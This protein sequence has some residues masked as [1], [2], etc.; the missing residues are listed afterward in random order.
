MKDL[1]VH[2]ERIVRPIPASGG[3][4]LRM[5]RELLAHLTAAFEEE[6]ARGL[7]D[8]A[9]AA[10]AKRRL[11]D[12]DELRRQLEQPV[13][14]IER[15]EGTYPKGLNDPRYPRMLGGRSPRTRLTQSIAALVL[16]AAV[17]LPALP[18]LLPAPASHAY[19]GVRA[20]S[21]PHARL[22]LAGSIVALELAT[23]AY[24]QFVVEVIGLARPRR[25]WRLAALT[26]AAIAAPALMLHLSSLALSGRPASIPNADLL[27]ATSTILLFMTAAASFM[28]WQARPL[29]EWLALD[30]GD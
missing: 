21:P 24:Y 12:P 2:V 29:Q 16:L 4:K 25:P 8:A 14:W 18:W 10:S 5:R 3:R 22:L 15:I 23:L 7:D 27:R 30:L 26:A 11:G 13:P 19:N 9:A 17:L 1:M 28:A 6:R 20:A